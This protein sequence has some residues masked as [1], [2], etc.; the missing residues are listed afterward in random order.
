MADAHRKKPRHRDDAEKGAPGAADYAM[1]LLLERLESLLEEMEELGVSS[2]AELEAR[3]AALHE[4][5]DQ[6][7]E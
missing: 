7:E 5:L 3:I 1:L 2:R 4:Q 6:T